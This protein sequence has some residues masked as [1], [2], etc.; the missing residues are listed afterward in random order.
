M[1]FVD[2]MTQVKL[3]C[4]LSQ[5]RAP[6]HNGCPDSKPMKG[7]RIQLRYAKI[8]WKSVDSTCKKVYIRGQWRSN[9]ITI[10]HKCLLE[11]TIIL[12]TLLWSVIRFENK[13][14]RN[15]GKMRS[16]NVFSQAFASLCSAESMSLTESE[17]FNEADTDIVIEHSRPN[18]TVYLADSTAL[19]W[20]R[21]I[22]DCPRDRC[23]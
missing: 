2:Y 11:T 4:V 18:F 5:K 7:W 14:Q 23:I 15:G 8:K 16:P 19:K 12:L 21:F 1:P 9:N 3:W 6:V 17:R 20:S 13:I 22:Y 10:S